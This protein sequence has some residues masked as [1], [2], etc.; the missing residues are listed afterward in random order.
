MALPA[1]R[2]IRLDAT[3]ADVTIVGSIDPIEAIRL[4]ARRL[5]VIRR[6]KVIAETPA[7]VAKLSL[8]G[9]PSR[10]DPADY[11]PKAAG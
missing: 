5:A 7:G 6:G 4:K 11:R 1:G 3:I 9:R 10:V 2:A 8:D